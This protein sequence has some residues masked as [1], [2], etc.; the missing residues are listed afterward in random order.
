MTRIIC[1]S[2]AK[3]KPVRRTARPGRP[4][5]ASLFRFT[6]YAIT[7]PGLVEPSDEDRAAVGQLFADDQAEPDRDTLAG[8]AAYVNAVSL[9]APPPGFCWS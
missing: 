6:P 2:D 8:E 4:F 1:T 5:G 3:V 9:L 7:A